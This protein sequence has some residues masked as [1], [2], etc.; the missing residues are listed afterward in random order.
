[1]RGM[2]ND[3]QGMVLQEPDGD[4]LAPANPDSSAEFPR[5]RVFFQMQLVFMWIVD[6]H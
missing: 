2:D 6:S 3:G 5:G 4:D 1:M